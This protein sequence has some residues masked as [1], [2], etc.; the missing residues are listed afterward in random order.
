MFV[1]YPTQSKD[2]EPSRSQCASP[3]LSHTIPLAGIGYESKGRKII[4][5]GLLKKRQK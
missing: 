1:D 2:A 3:I 5:K 4:S